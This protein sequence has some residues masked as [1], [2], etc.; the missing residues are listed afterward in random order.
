MSST[1]P[2]TIA[3]TVAV[4]VRGLTALTVDESV[5]IY[6]GSINVQCGYGTVDE[7]RIAAVDHACGLIGDADWTRLAW[8]YGETARAGGQV[9][10]YRRTATIDGVEWAVWCRL[11]DVAVVLDLQAVAA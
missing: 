7:D 2:T 11:A 9:G 3:E 4:A 5:T 1:R 10:S 8:L 6:P